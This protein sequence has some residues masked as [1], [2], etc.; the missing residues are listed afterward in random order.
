MDILRSVYEFNSYTVHRMMFRARP[1]YIQDVNYSV[2]I[3]RDAIAIQCLA[4][5]MLPHGDCPRVL[6]QPKE[7]T[8]PTPMMDVLATAAEKTGITGDALYRQIAMGNRTLLR[9]LILDAGVEYTVSH[10]TARNTYTPFHQL[11]LQKM[12]GKFTVLKVAKMVNSGRISHMECRKSHGRY[13]PFWQDMYDFAKQI[14]EQGN[15]S[16]KVSQISE[17]RITIL[18]CSCDIYDFYFS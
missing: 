10:P 3:Y 13:G 14:W 12:D 5:A 18:D 7:N 6:I 11:P 1:V 9:T 15:C 16:C 2:G 8:G 4:N 17:D